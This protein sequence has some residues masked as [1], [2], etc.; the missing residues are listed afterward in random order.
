MTLTEKLLK[1]AENSEALSGYRDWITYF[2]KEDRQL[3]KETVYFYNVQPGSAPTIQASGNR[4]ATTAHFE[5]GTI[6]RADGSL[7]LIH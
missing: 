2:K 1:K 7:Y 3:N 5:I 4:R 6:I